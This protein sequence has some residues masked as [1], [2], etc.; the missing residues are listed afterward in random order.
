MLHRRRILGALATAALLAGGAGAALA[1]HGRGGG[2][3]DA[4]RAGERLYTLQPDPAGNPEGVAYDRRS[5]SFFVSITG[6]GAIYRG[7][8]GDDTVRPYIAGGAGRASVGLEIRGGRL[9][10]AGGPTGTITV[11]DI[12]SGDAI[13][14]FD[15]GAGGFLNDVAVTRGGDVYVT[16]SFRPTL[17]HVTARQVRAGGGTP[18][19]LDVAAIPYEAGEFNV[20]GIVAKAARKLVV[21]DSNSGGLYRIVLGRDRA[22]IRSIA[23]IAGVT[24]PGGDGMLRDRGLL[25]VVQ[26][27]PAQL[28]FIKLRR[29]ARRATLRGTRT[30]ALLNGPSTVDRARRHY[31]VVNADFAT[32][33]PPF[34]VAGLPRRPR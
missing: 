20:N 11:Y 21:V 19:A 32:S 7:T 10:V 2:R 6:D 12:A 33:T 34:T 27:D 9:Y 24:V 22:S 16:D 8:P 14:T 25:V 30:S 3:D 5:R 17:W 15:T 1:D 26:G 28:S 29:D 13:A 23:A 31:L 18:T 4:R